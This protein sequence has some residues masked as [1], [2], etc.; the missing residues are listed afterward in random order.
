MATTTLWTYRDA[1]DHLLDWQGSG[2]ADATGLR[3]AKRAILAAYND[4]STAKLWSYYYQRGRIS[5]VDDYSTGT[6]T[7][8]NSTRNC[9]LAS[10]TW[11]S[12]AARGVIQIAE[13]EYQVASRT[14]G[15]TIVLSVN[16]NPGADVAAGTAYKIYQDTYTLP[17]DFTALGEVRD[18]ANGIWL[19]HVEPDAWHVLHTN[20]D[21]PSQPLW[22]C[23]RQDPDYQGVLGMSLYPPPDAIYR[24]DFMYRRQPRRLLV[25]QYTTGTVTT[26]STAVT[27]TGTVFPANCAGSVIR[28]GADGTTAPT[29]VAGANPFGSERIITV[30]GGDTSLTI[31]SALTAELTAVK[32]EISDPIDLE[33]GAMF[34]AF[35]RRAE[36]ELGNLNVLDEKRQALLISRMRAAEIIAR[37]ADNRVF[38]KRTGRW[39]DRLN[40]SFDISSMEPT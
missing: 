11:P 5:T 20:A 24:L 30:R 13:V 3:K 37:E 35:L 18:V 39:Y 32:Y 31:D 26:S 19:E 36:Y 2:S 33:Q 6:I 29:G 27:G 40:R 4:L 15:T 16:A 28:F 12:W 17:V 23:I 21:T 25:P 14:D 22:F 8:T 7:Y 9:V 38:S 34:A 10:G 1:L